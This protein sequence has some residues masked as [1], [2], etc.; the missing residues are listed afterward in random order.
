MDLDFSMEKDFFDGQIEELQRTFQR[1]LDKSFSTLGLKAFDVVF[2]KKPEE[3]PDELK[4]FWGG[5]KLEYKLI[6]LEKYS[7]D[8]QDIA[9]LRRSAIR[10]AGKQKFEIDFSPFEFVATKSAVQFNDYTV[11]V[12]SPLMI[13]CEKMRAICQQTEEYCAVINSQGPHPRPRDFYDIYYIM[14]KLQ[15]DLLSSESLE[16]VR[17][18]FAV[19]RVP[20]N[21]LNILEKY[22]S[23][24]KEDEQSLYATLKPDSEMLDFDNYFDFV[25]PLANDLYKALGSPAP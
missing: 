3:L 14:K 5:Y 6:E 16:V 21:I 17:Q 2:E 22:R 9:S 12:Y 7:A 10:A 18:M 13:V 20:L 1:V 23:L 11:Y 8:E 19:K 24:H 4:S 15:V 25:V